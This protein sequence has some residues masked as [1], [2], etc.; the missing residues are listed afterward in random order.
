[1]IQVRFKQMLRSK[2]A[3]LM[4][5][6]SNSTQKMNDTSQTQINASLSPLV[7]A[8]LLGLRFSQYSHHP[9]IVTGTLSDRLR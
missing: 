6:A 4:T 8:L 5:V 7:L 3:V 2:R 1:M 9:S